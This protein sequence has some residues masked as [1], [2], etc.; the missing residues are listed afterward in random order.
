M[1]ALRTFADKNKGSYPSKIVIY[2]DGVGEQMRD[3]IIAK[4]IAQFK[5][6]V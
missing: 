2:R 1:S 6:A 3:Q 4:E 5:A